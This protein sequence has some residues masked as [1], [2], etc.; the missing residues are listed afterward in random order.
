M[1]ENIVRIFDYKSAPEKLITS[2]IIQ[3]IATIHEHKGKQELFMEATADDLTTM[4]EAAK[5]QS[6]GASI[7]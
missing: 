6:T 7:G 4:L 5:I 2:D 3:L 1:K